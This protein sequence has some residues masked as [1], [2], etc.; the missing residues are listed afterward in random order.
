M[1][2]V[3]HFNWVINIAIY[4]SHILV[5]QFPRKRCFKSCPL[6]FSSK[7]LKRTFERSFFVIHIAYAART[8][9]ASSVRS[10]KRSST[11]LVRLPPVAPTIEPFPRATFAGKAYVNAASSFPLDS[12]HGD[13]GRRMLLDHLAVDSRAHTI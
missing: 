4:F 3:D 10:S 8:S 12:L 7:Q 11:K 5:R 2:A 6:R 9:Y 1:I 13:E